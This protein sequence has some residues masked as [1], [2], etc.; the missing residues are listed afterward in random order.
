MKTFYR[1][2]QLLLIIFLASY[3][4]FIFTSKSN[5]TG[6]GGGGGGT[7]TNCLAPN[8]CSCAS[9]N[10]PNNRS[11]Q[12]NKA[13]WSQLGIPQSCNIGYVCKNGPNG[14][15]P[16][17]VQNNNTHLTC[18]C[19]HPDSSNDGEN[20]ISC[21]DS[22]GNTQT[23]VRFCP[24]WELCTDKPSPAT[25]A[26]LQCA[27]DNPGK[28]GAGNNGMNCGTTYNSGAQHQISKHVY[29]TENQVCVNGSGGTAT[30]QDLKCTCDNPGQVGN[31]NNGYT[32]TYAGDPKGYHAYCPNSGLACVNDSTQASGINCT[33]QQKLIATTTPIPPPPPPC[34]VPLQNGSCPA[35]NTAF[36]T[37]ST[38]PSQ[39]VTNL[40]GVLLSLSG[41]IGVLIIMIAGYRLM[42]SQ[43][44]PERIQA[45]RE[46]ITA[47]IVGILFIIFS[48]VILQ[49]IGVD[50]L[51]IPGFK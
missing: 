34:A 25:C 13:C 20:G 9:P 14:Q 31:G 15:A 38:D 42:M 1:S 24:A 4:F 17:C 28:A 3:F 35:V 37:W 39:F 33:N 5:A 27:C 43:G 22:N 47:A 2:I 51:H 50:L 8:M 44:D 23:D 49:I 41:A 19:T 21:S 48:F 45:A 6:G 29:C 36:G 26:P 11:I 46:Q 18:H 40:F 32:C 30:C 12:C 10:D 16:S 7:P